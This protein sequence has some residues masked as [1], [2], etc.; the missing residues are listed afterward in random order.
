M[1]ILGCSLIEN[2]W[3]CEQKFQKYVVTSQTRFCWQQLYLAEK[4]FRHKRE[5]NNN[6]CKS[7]VTNELPELTIGETLIEF[8]LTQ[9]I[10]VWF[11][12]FTRW[13]RSNVLL[14]CQS[15][16]EYFEQLTLSGG[17]FCY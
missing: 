17:P 7:Q 9:Y 3:I 16:V 4:T 6:I 2:L 14:G 11:G 8:K 13:R 1:S 12:S 10:L 5:D 15:V